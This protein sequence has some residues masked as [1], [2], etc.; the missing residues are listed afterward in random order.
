MIGG[1]AAGHKELADNCNNCHSPF[2]NNFENCDT[3]HKDIKNISLHKKGAIKCIYCHKI[4]D[5]GFKTLSRTSCIYKECHGDAIKK[6]EHSADPN[7]CF[8]CHPEHSYKRGTSSIYSDLV[9]SH[10]IHTDKSNSKAY[11]PCVSCHQVS[12]SGIKMTLPEAMIQCKRCHSD[13]VE[14][15]DIKKSIKD[16][17]CAKCHYHEK[18]EIAGMGKDSLLR[19]ASFD[20][21]K[22]LDIECTIC[23]FQMEI[24]N[25]VDEISILDKKRK[26]SLCV[27]C[28]FNPFQTDG[29][30][31]NPILGKIVKHQS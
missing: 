27:K 18:R 2:K 9:F 22:H 1:L 5:M 14:S 4:H 10:R 11:Y 23:H 3:C 15:H 20:H 12:G 25:E 21:K 26:Y 29:S 13:W 28:H 19:L 7:I 17:K 8:N 16:E 6:A 24:F 30:K 31:Q